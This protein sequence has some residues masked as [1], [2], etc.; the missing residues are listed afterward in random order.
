MRQRIE[1]VL[2]YAIAKRWRAGPN[3]ALWRGNLKPMFVRKDKVQIVRHHAALDWRQ[4]HAFMDQLA[5]AEGVGAMALRFLVLCAN[6]TGEVT[7]ARWSE[8]DATEA[9]WTIPADRM[10]AKREHRIPLTTDAL[11]IL[12]RIEAH[13]QPSDPDVYVFPGDRPGRGLSNMTMQAVLRRM[14]RSDVTVHGMR[15]AFRDWCAE[16]GK[17]NDLAEAALAHTLGSKVQT[18]Y[19]RGDLLDRRRRLMDQWALFCATPP[20]VGDNVLQLHAATG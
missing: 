17:P 8:I 20:A 15:S 2:D 18:A 13:R 9:V 7:G 19:Q 12:R 10:K 11:A 5:Q 1:L 4:M 16:T 14:D 3:P 6:C